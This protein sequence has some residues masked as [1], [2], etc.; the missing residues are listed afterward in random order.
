MPGYEKGGISKAAFTDE[1]CILPLIPAKFLISLNPLEDISWQKTA[2][3]HARTVVPQAEVVT[4]RYIVAMIS[5]LI[6]LA[7]RR[8]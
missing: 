1:T 2:R 6:P 5:D 4:R 8:D 7:P 3:P